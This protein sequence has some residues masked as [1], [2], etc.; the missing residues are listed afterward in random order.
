ML[1]DDFLPAYDERERH[2]VEVHASLDTV[3]A[4]VRKLDLSEARLSRFLFRLRGISTSR[5]FSLDD[6]LKM[7]FILLGEKPN[8]EL[9]LGLIG[10]F[11][12]LSGGLQRLDTEG[13][14]KFN[15]NGFAKAVWNFS[16]SAQDVNKVKLETETRVSCMDEASRKRFRRYWLVVGRFSGLIRRDILHAIKRNAEAM[17]RSESRE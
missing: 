17:A 14:R 6:L 1:I 9:L 8:E 12:T 2:S 13:F 5:G 10:R 7:R 16:L 11:W 15:E 3:Y 4:A